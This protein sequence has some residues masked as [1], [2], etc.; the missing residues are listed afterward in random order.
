MIEY[1]IFLRTVIDLSLCKSMFLL[2][3][4]N[5]NEIG[6]M[7]RPDIASAG[8][9][10]QIDLPQRKKY[11]I[12]MCAMLTKVVVISC[13]EKKTQISPF[14]KYA[15]LLIEKKRPQ[16]TLKYET[17]A[18]G[19]LMEQTSNGTKAAGGICKFVIN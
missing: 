16:G 1:K 3:K 8:I 15:V 7:A 12:H 2:T 4:I 14:G 17:L 5:Q 9:Y 11:D 6:F 10:S 18:P 13:G 19:L